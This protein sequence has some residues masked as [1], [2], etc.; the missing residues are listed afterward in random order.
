MYEEPIV[1]FRTQFLSYA[2]T[3]CFFIYA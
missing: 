1:A 3:W 2:S